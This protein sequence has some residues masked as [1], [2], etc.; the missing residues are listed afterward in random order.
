MQTSQMNLFDLVSSLSKYVLVPCLTQYVTVSYIDLNI[1]KCLP[2]IPMLNNLY[3]SAFLST[4]PNAFLD[5][6][7]HTANVPSHS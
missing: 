2:L 5:Q 1:S 4:E 3:Q 7:K 6:Q